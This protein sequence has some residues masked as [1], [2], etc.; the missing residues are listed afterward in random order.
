MAQKDG[1][2]GNR[3]ASSALIKRVLETYDEFTGASYGYEPNADGQDVAYAGTEAANAIGKAFDPN[4]RFIPYWYRDEAKGGQLTLTPL[5][6]MESPYYD[7]CRQ[8][9]LELGRAEVLVTEPYVYEGKLIVE[10]SYPLVK[11]GRFVGVA[12]TDRALADIAKLLNTI[13][14][15]QHVDV[16]LISSQGN[17]IATTLGLQIRTKHFSE[18]DYAEVFAPFFKNRNVKQTVLKEDPADDDTTRYSF[19]TAPV[20]TGDWQ[21]V[22]RQSQIEVLGPILAHVLKM[23]AVAFI[24]LLIVVGFIWWFSTSMV[25]RI[26]HAMNAADRL[27]S[28]D[29]S[30]DLTEQS[31]ASDEIGFMFR[32]FKR[33]VDSYRQINDVCA[34]IAKGDFSRRVP[35]RS[36]NDSLAEAI[37]LVAERRQKAEEE[38]KDYTVQLEIRA[39]IESSLSQLSTNLQGDLSV[40]DVA[41]RGLSALID[42]LEVP[43]AAI[44][45]IASDQRV[46]RLAAHAYPEDP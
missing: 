13:K 37:N 44:F 42:F 9:F 14:N 8:Q 25:Y 41:S 31:Q 35:P 16:F 5:V 21:V 39:T 27:A 29:L 15:T 43:A 32:S 28:G 12:C 20:P 6:D 36:D 33:V 46:H 34:A 40:Q 24:G 4:G 38:V 11:D 45:V 2:F 3:E 1:L 22:V 30:G 26:S 18:T 19:T 7:G 10:Q 23:T 17:F